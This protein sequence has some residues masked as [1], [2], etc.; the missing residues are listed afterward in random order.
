MWA[1]SSA[2]YGAEKG[3]N[4]KKT[5]TFADLGKPDIR[6][7]G[8]TRKP[9]KTVTMT[10]EDAR[11][12]SQSSDGRESAQRMASIRDKDALVTRSVTETDTSDIPEIKDLGKFIRLS[13]RP[14]HPLYHAVTL[15]SPSG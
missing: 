13:D 12:W 11:K 10:R 1:A 3:N 8:D 4:M 7:S 14:E 6:K 5:K 9:G 2:G 15:R